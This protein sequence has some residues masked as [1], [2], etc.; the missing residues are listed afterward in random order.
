M[1]LYW[2]FFHKALIHRMEHAMKQISHI[3]FLFI[4]ALF[5]LGAAHSAG[6]DI[7]QAQG[8]TFV[9]PTLS[10][11]FAGNFTD[12]FVYALN[13]ELG[14]KNIRLD[15]TAGW[16]TGD[17]QRFKVTAEYLTQRLTYTYF[18]GNTEPWTSQGALGLDYGLELV[19]VYFNPVIGFNA[20]IAHSPSQ[21][22]TPYPGVFV[23]GSGVSIPIQDV[24]RIAGTSMSGASPGVTFR[25]WDTGTVGVDLNYDSVRYDTDYV[26]S[27]D[28]RGLG[29][30]FRFSQ[31]IT[32]DAQIALLATVR[33]QYDNYSARFSLANL[34]YLD[35]WVFAFNAAYTIGK[36]TAPNSYNL[37]LG[38]DYF[39][40]RNPS[41]STSQRQAA[42]NFLSWAMKPAVYVPQVMGIP[43]EKVT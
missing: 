17:Y 12:T 27:Q 29:G 15:G 26:A 2:L 18:S 22:L 42:E 1:Y 31:A 25:F 36:Q 4:C 37:G 43:D 16:Q 10:G 11:A 33:Q 39:L 24:R 28:T 30:T 20:Y 41:T 23:T 32:D 40:E 13:G 34:P 35:M 6:V 19:D 5:S 14:K 9:G 21:Q 3:I 38:A 8:T 7:T